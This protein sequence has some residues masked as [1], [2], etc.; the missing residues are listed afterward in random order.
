MKSIICVLLLTTSA[1]WIEAKRERYDEYTVYRIKPK[2]EAQMKLIDEL[3]KNEGVDLWTKVRQSYVDI[4]ISPKQKQRFHEF[5]E[6]HDLDISVFIE[7]GQK[8]IDDEVKV[9]K[10]NHR[11]GLE[12]NFLYYYRLDVIYRHLYKLEA[13]Y[14]DIAK[15][16]TIGKSYE[17][18]KIKGLH[19]SRKQNTRTIIIEGGIHAREWIAPATTMFILSRVLNNSNLNQQNLFDE[20]NWYIFPVV[21][22]DGYEYTHTTDRLWRKTRQPNNGSRCFGTDGNRNFDFHWREIGVSSDPCSETYGGPSAFSEPETRALSDFIKSQKDNLW[23][24]VAFHSYSQLLL[25]PYGYTSEHAENNDDLQSIGNAASMAL[26]T[27]FNTSYVVGSVYETIYGAS[28]SSM[29]W[30]LGV[31]KT[32]LSFTYEL[33]DKG[34][35]GFLL[36]SNQITPCGKEIV[37]SF[38]ALISQA[39]KLG[40]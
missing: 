17:G 14:P 10:P 38:E 18:R 15:V 28:G 1:I 21:N 25:F 34:R 22:P 36:P 4:M 35:F 16:V 2:N 33:R 32:P 37:D 24:Y 9:N 31:V 26:F 8:L 7:N 27:R 13:Q 40:Y 23:M 19:I 39:E 11:I 29:D 5:V 3:G 6:K 12:F 30:V 20:F